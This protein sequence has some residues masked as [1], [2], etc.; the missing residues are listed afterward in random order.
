MDEAHDAVQSACSTPVAKGHSGGSGGGSS[1]SSYGS[2]RVTLPP[3][4]AAGSPAVPGAACSPRS[5]AAACSPKAPGGNHGPSGYA[6]RPP[7]AP[8][9]SNLCP[10]K[11]RQTIVQYS[12]GSLATT[13]RTVDCLA[14]EESN[15]FFSDSGLLSDSDHE[16]D[17]EALQER[18]DTIPEAPEEGSSL[19]SELVGGKQT[20]PPTSAS[21]DEE[22][23]SDVGTDH[24][25]RTELSECDIN[26]LEELEEAS[27]DSSMRSPLV[28][29]EGGLPLPSELPR[30]PPVV[31]LV[32]AGFEIPEDGPPFSAS[33]E[34]MVDSDRPK[35]YLNL[36]SR[37]MLTRTQTSD[38]TLAGLRRHECAIGRVRHC[39]SMEK[40]ALRISDGAKLAQNSQWLESFIARARATPLH[41]AA[42]TLIGEGVGTSVAAFLDDLSDCS[43]AGAEIDSR[44][45]PDGL[46][47]FGPRAFV[48]TPRIGRGRPGFVVDCDTEIPT[49]GRSQSP[50]ARRAPPPLPM[51]PPSPPMILAPGQ[52][53]ASR[54]LIFRPL[55]GP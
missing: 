25:S 18:F 38:L 42:D 15:D 17:M 3:G 16:L 29:I 27:A 52:Q 33:P 9:P 47:V 35:K 20:R 13:Y 31:W 54:R 48:R 10:A 44:D 1:S 23:L 51:E 11:L 28:D 32:A 40:Q 43:C 46:H 6:P 49:P 37:Q 12:I 19:F 34:A 22:V 21:L 5:P 4:A 14:E 26:D 8:K 53:Q 50:P 2:A 39:D 30:F 45:V 24:M 7:S 36:F 55:W 41:V